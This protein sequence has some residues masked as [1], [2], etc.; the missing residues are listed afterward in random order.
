M[1]KVANFKLNSTPT[2]TQVPTAGPPTEEPKKKGWFPWSGGRTK[3]R[4]SNR[5][6]TKRSKRSKRS[7]KSKK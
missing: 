6:K 3:K 2:V 7:K 4:N 5:K 1:T